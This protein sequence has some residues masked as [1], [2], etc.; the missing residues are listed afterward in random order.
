MLSNESFCVKVRFGAI[1]SASKTKEYFLKNNMIGNRPL[2]SE[3]G[4]TGITCPEN[5]NWWLARL[6]SEQFV[7]EIPKQFHN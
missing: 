2:F 1:Y 5:S 7:F 4:N 3:L 6:T